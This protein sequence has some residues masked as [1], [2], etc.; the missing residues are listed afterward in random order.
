[1]IN[2]SLD[3]IKTVDTVLSQMTGNI[4]HVTS[5]ISKKV[6]KII[7]W[8]DD[9]K[10]DIHVTKNYVKA[11]IKNIIDHKLTPEKIQK[12]S[13]ELSE[14]RKKNKEIFNNMS[15]RAQNIERVKLLGSAVFLLPGTMIV[16]LLCPNRFLSKPAIDLRRKWYTTVKNIYK[17]LNWKNIALEECTT[18][19]TDSEKSMN[20]SVISA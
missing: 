14:Y 20:L 9:V 15:P 13:Q 17:R 12:M 8:I 11:S 6:L 7:P 2:H 1:M 5:E 3:Y 19:K 10:N 18:E 16:L 4:I